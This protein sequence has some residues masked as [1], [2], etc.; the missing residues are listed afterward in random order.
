MRNQAILFILMVSV[1]MI[2]AGTASAA[3]SVNVTVV[4]D[5]GTPVDVA[6]PGDDVG[7]M[8]VAATNNE[9]LNHPA[10]LI[11]TNP[12]DGLIYDVNNAMMSTDGI[13]WIKN[14]DPI[15][16]FGWSDQAE[17]WVWAIS[18]I[19][20]PMF[21]GDVVQLFIPAT[22]IDTGEI[23]TNVI[24]E[25]GMDEEVTPAVNSFTFLSVAP[26]PPIA[27]AGTVPMQD[28]GAPVAVAALGLL[29]VLGG[30]IYSRLR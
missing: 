6:Q 29:A 26:A 27:A 4:Q 2:F 10:A 20:G 14:N 30:T 15:K 11:K 12:D 16:F 3:L 9:T 8:V 17:S 1:G 19:T 28:T 21:P 25:G 23:T 18:Q 13:N 5:N 22:V 7:V 24:F